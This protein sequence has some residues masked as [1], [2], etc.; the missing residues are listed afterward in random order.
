MMLK[1][2]THHKLTQ[3]G[4]IWLIISLTI[5]VI[6]LTFIEPPIAQDPSYHN[7]ADQRTIWGIPNFYNVISNTA[8][9]AVGIG[10]L[11]FLWRQHRL[12]NHSAFIEPVEEW[13]YFVL[14]LGVGLTSFGSAYYHLQPNDTHLVWD[15]LPMTFAFM[16]FFA[17]TIM[18]HIQ[19]KAGLRLL[20]ALILLG[21]ASVIYWYAGDL[22]GGGGDLRFYV[23]IQFYPLL[24]IPLI[25]ALFPPRYVP[26]WLIFLVILLY[27]LAK[28]FELWDVR[29][30][31]WLGWVSGHTL[32]HLTAA[33]AT[34][35]IIWILAVRKPSELAK[36]VPT[37]AII[38]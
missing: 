2:H 33:L 13:P 11:M 31:N 10:G 17:A 4:R 15:R 18:E 24:T 28:L 3:K 34:Y 36:D 16:A 35:V 37:T 12:R 14:F 29:I 22:R 27:A 38:N 1:H 26:N 8:F 20:P 30:F 25:A 21:V 32:K 6:L 19:L 23:D 5:P 9:L 7:F